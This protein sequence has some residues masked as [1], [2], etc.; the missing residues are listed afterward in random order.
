MKRRIFIKL[1]HLD[2]YEKTMQGIFSVLDSV[3]LDFLENNPKFIKF[4]IDDL[5]EYL[6]TLKYGK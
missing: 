2:N 5:Q 3:F 1:T 4:A 6:D